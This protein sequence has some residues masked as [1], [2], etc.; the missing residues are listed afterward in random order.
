MKRVKCAI[1]TMSLMLAALIA[2][3]GTPRIVY[4]SEADGTALFKAKCAACHGVDGKGETAAGKAMKLRDLGSA[5]VQALSDAEL[6]EITAKGKGKMPGYHK[7][8][9]DDGVQAVVAFIRTLKR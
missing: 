4:A 8:I 3:P 6:A 1:I 2:L 5:E 9:G 7:S